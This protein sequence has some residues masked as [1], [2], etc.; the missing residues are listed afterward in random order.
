MYTYP[1]FFKTKMLVWPF[2]FPYVRPTH[3]HEST[4]SSFFLPAAAAADKPS[5]SS[6][7]LC[8]LFK[9][10]CQVSDV[11]N[12]VP[13]AAAAAARSIIQKPSVRDKRQKKAMRFLPRARA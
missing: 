12:D 2:F 6:L 5:H 7:D 3:A 11:I 4:C 13:A 8:S 9:G 1:G 10:T